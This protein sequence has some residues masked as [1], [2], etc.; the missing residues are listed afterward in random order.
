ME[1]V[2]ICQRHKKSSTLARAAFF[3]PLA[4]PLPASRPPGNRICRNSVPGAGIP[5]AA[6]TCRPDRTWKKLDYS[7]KGLITPASCLPIYTENYLG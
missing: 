6:I 1:P 2:A 4:L 5:A 3:V 7:N